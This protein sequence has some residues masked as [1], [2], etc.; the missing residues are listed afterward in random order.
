MADK[1]KQ[2]IYTHVSGKALKGL[3]RLEPAGE[4]R[5]LASPSSGD[6]TVITTSPSKPRSTRIIYNRSASKKAPA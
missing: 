5:V 2:R 1:H 6:F 3:K 4:M